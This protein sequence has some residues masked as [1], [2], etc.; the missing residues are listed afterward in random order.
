MGLVVLSGVLVT[1]TLWEP[2][3]DYWVIG[4][5]FFLLAFGIGNLMAPSTDSVMG[6]VPEANAGIAS[7]MNDVTRQV[8]G[9]FGVAVIGSVYQ[10]G[11]QW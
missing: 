8:A 5:T 2:D 7:A 3:T 10:H 1:I 6:A 11:V 4:L 9:A